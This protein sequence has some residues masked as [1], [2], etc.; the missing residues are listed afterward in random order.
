MLIFLN[1]DI[2]PKSR[3]LFL[4]PK[5]ATARSGL[6][7]PFISPKETSCAPLPALYTILLSNCIKPLILEFL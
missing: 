3:N 5:F 7:S 4:F 2:F 6:P 1:N